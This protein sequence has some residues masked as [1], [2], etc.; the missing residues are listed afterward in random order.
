MHIEG[1]PVVQE[2]VRHIIHDHHGKIQRV[3]QADNILAWLKN[4]KPIQ[5]SPIKKLR[6]IMQEAD[7]GELTQDQQAFFELFREQLYRSVT[8]TK[9]SGATAQ[10]L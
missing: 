9:G 2:K 1:A 6:N 5:E 4:T 8:R 10:S 7:L 3:S